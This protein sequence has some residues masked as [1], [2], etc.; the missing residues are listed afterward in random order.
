MEVTAAA[1]R[2]LVSRTGE[3]P[4]TSVYLNTDGAQHPRAQ[5]YEARLDGLLREVRKTAEAHQGA[6]RAGILADADAIRRWVRGFTR[7]DV[8]GIGLF[9]S[10]GEVFEEVQAAIGVRNVARV[11]ATPYVVPL[12]VLLG[13]HHHVGLVVI[14]RD[15]ARIF[16]YRLGRLEQF[17]DFT[18]DVHG[19]H[20]Q[21]GWS[22][23]RFQNTIEEEVRQHMKEA[24]EILRQAHA[25][26][27]FD[28]LV[29]AGPHTEAVELVKTLHPYLADLVH[30]DPI[31]IPLHASE[32][33]LRERLSEVEQ[34]L[35]SE[36]RSALLQRLFASQGA[37]A[38]GA[39][40]VRA[41]LDAV[42]QKAV[43]VLFVVE[44]AGE[45]GWRSSNGA[46][47]LRSDDA[48]A[49]GGD[50]EPVA[51]LIDEIIEDAVRSG[52]H[53]ELFR[54]PVRLDGHPVAAVRR[55]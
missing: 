9:S 38:K 34:A 21:G 23:R 31:S 51:D 30:G 16:R 19:Q 10:G 46:L 5:D 32:K 26:E 7:G 6:A 11:N 18:S 13:R 50:V 42:N 39:W 40:G 20:E 29:V 54:D 53:V 55:F 25:D 14:E 37:G 43:E 3:L 44:G 36:R 27:P 45:A 17:R 4:V 35:V 47:A 48:R 33:E 24:S 12:E 22:Q 1:I 28:A 15:E 8:R 52:A 41:V 2:T 49:F